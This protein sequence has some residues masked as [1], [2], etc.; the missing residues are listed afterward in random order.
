MPL[1]HEQTTNR[2]AYIAHVPNQHMPLID[3]GGMLH[4]PIAE[5]VDALNDIVEELITSPRLTS[6]QRK[7]LRL[8][9][10]LND[11]IIKELRQLAAYNHHTH[12]AAPALHHNG[13]NN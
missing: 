13:G 6:A 2:P 12:I 11:T 1:K 8:A 9:L 10:L 3:N 5:A 7:Q 4:H